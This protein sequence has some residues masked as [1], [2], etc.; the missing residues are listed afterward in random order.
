MIEFGV[1]GIDPGAKLPAPHATKFHLL[2]LQ[3]F[4]DRMEEPRRKQN[5][6][7]NSI[8]WMEIQVSKLTTQWSLNAPGKHCNA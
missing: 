2:Q 6:S 5:S 4:N 8:Y 3:E 1:D 7:M